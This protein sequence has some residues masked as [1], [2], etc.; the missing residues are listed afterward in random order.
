MRARPTILDGHVHVGTWDHPPFCGHGTTFDESIA[1][2][3][4]AGVAG[5][6]VTTTDRRDHV[7]LV[8]ACAVPRA[9]RTWAALWVSPTT[10][11]AD[12]DAME[13]LAGRYRALKLHPSL[14]RIAISDDV[15]RPFLREAERR[16]LPVVVHCGRWLPMAGWTLCLDL[17]A[18]WP[19]VR[20]ILAHMGGDSPE[21]GQAAVARAKAD[22]LENVWFGTESIREYWS[23]QR[24]I[25]A[26]G[27][28]R[29]V[30]GSD[31]NLAHP[32]TYLP[33]IDALAISAEE[34]AQVYAGN[35]RGLVGLA[36]GDG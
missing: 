29:F 17:A 6:L 15:W 11:E 31:H 2:L 20:F 8:E 10:L 22:R 25:D 12:L 28:S 4:A 23:V 30:Y 9:V 21:L 34:R 3:Q 14:S 1:M 13:Q 19:T 35:L 27:P 7:A 24:A 33:V 16:A 32:A 5:A 36:E 18:R 26:L